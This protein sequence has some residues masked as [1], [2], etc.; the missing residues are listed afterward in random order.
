MVVV[1]PR[2][3]L[4]HLPWRIAAGG[5]SWRV[6][7]QGRACVSAC[8]LLSDELAC[9]RWGKPCVPP[10]K[11]T[12]HMLAGHRMTLPCPAA[13]CAQPANGRRRIGGPARA[14]ALPQTLLTL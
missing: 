7:G 2:H 1:H 10:S 9:R 11:R 4:E 5:E 12:T 3:H 8:R 14:V 6:E 13:A